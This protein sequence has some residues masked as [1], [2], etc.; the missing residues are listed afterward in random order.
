M[1]ISAHFPNSTI[2]TIDGAGHWVQAEKP[3][4]FAELV[5]GFL[6]SQ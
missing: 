1:D 4:E 6:S 2:E 5:L 3:E